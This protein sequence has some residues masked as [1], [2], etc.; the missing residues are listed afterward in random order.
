[1]FLT[2]LMQKM[3][4][5]TKTKKK[6]PGSITQLIPGAKVDVGVYCCLPTRWGVRF[7]VRR[8]KKRKHN[9]LL[10]CCISTSSSSPFRIKVPTTLPS[11]FLLWST[12]LYIV[13]ILSNV[14][15]CFSWRAYAYE[16]KIV[17]YFHL[18]LIFIFYKKKKK[19]FQRQEVLFL[20]CFI[21]SSLD[22]K[23]WESQC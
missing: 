4:N 20:F 17:I 10:L 13:F 16:K 5:L 19:N 7:R 6:S 22:P 15:V 2:F 21:L 12:R 3:Q 11:L 23:F 9:I 1:M 18:N 8:E 14:L